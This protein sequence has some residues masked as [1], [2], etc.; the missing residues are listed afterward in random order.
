MQKASRFIIIGAHPDDCDEL[1]A[2]TAIQL[3]ASGCAVKFVSVCNGDCGHQSMGHVELAQRRYGEA[4]A[5]AKLCG[6]TEYQVLEHH[7]CE[8]VADLRLRAEIV[9]IIRRF[10]PDVVISHRCCDYHADHRNTG[11]AV[12]DAA[13]L[14]KVPLYC[15]DTPIPE[16]NPVF[17]YSYD[18][19]TDPRPIRP[20]AAVPIDSV[21]EKKLHVMACH[22]SQYF[23]WLPWDKGFK[24]FDATSMSWE[25]KREW[26]LNIWEAR[27]I[28]QAD[29]AREQLV[30]TYGEAGRNVRHAELFEY[31]PY[32]ENVTPEEFQALFTDAIRP[33]A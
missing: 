11:Q 7:D 19:F 4:Q 14:V 10:Q 22:E 17:A 23:E 24:N 27:T 6:I 31:S 9:R 21:I 30:R 3:A 20:D 33:Q 29:L 1:F 32:G 18:R 12:I 16:R 13:Y 8:V 2:G 5:A 25:Q 15:E 28:S 26:L